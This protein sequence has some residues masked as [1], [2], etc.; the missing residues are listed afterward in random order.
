MPLIYKKTTSDIVDSLDEL[1]QMSI[2]SLAVFFN[3]LP[4]RVVYDIKILNNVILADGTKQNG[5]FQRIITGYDAKGNAK[6]KNVN[7]KFLVMTISMLTDG[8]IKKKIEDILIAPLN[9]LNYNPTTAQLADF[10][11]KLPLNLKGIITP[12]MNTPTTTVPPPQGTPQI[13]PTIGDP[14]KPKT[15]TNPGGK[16]RGSAGERKATA[17]GKSVFTNNFGDLYN[18]AGE[19][20]AGDTGEVIK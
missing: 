8:N 17:G 15:E 14:T 1:K 3:D 9:T 13:D 6:Y 16:L 19:R 20:V 4:A 2:N 7:N 10:T 12:V 5:G 11:T 18:I